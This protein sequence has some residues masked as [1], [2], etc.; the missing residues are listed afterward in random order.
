MEFLVIDFET[1]GLS[2]VNERIIEIGYAL[3]RDMEIVEVGSQ[4]VRP[5]KLI[6]NPKIVEITGIDNTMLLDAPSLESE[7]EKIYPMLSGRLIVAHNAP[8]DMGFLNSTLY[9]M[10][11]KTFHSYLCT[12]E[13]FRGYKKEKRLDF[14]GASLAKMVEYFGLTNESAHRAGADAKVTAQALIEMCKEIDFRDY[15]V[16]P[17]KRSKVY[18]SLEKPTKRDQYMHMFDELTPIEEICAH[19]NVK[20]GTVGK[21]FMEWMNYGDIE[22]YKTFIIEH[23]PDANIVN[24]IVKLK[25][26]G[27]RSND[28]YRNLG[29]QVEY[30]DIQLV[31]RLHSRGIL[32]EYTGG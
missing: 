9:R 26:K 15:M 20:I 12:A 10:G 22:P 32:S 23:I 21:Y 4:L 3:I 2:A 1:T 7:I 18:N 28:I 25:I 5:D 17:S 30:F 8:F 13:M 11:L 14:R 31:S 24:E 6:D 27:L 19:F 29:G 16:G